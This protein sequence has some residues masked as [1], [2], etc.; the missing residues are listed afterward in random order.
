MK[1]DTEHNYAFRRR[2][3]QVHQP[4]RRNRL[5]TPAAKE[6]AL[7]DD[8]TIVLPLEASDYLFQVAQ[9][10]QDYLA[11]SMNV[12]VKIIRLDQADG[13]AGSDARIIAIG[14]RDDFRERG[15]RLRKPRAF[16]LQV[17]PGRIVI[18]GQDERGAAQGCYRLEDIMNLR[19]APF[20]P[21]Q[22]TV[23][24]PLFA[25]RMVHS[26]WGIDNF[27]D[28][29]LNAIAHAGIDAILV[30]TKDIN[31]TNTGHLDFANLIDR[32]E[33]FGL[34]VYFYSY[35]KSRKHPDD[36]EAV[37]FYENS[38]GKLIRTFPKAKGIVFVGESCEFPSKDERT[39]GRLRLDPAPPGQENDKRPS[40]GWWPCRD[41]PQWL[42]LV[43]GIMR[44]YN[45]DL[46]VVFWTYN[47]GLAPAQDRLALINNLPTDISLEVTFEM[48]ENIVKNG[49][50]TRCVDY[51]A[52]FV[53]PGTYFRTE[54]ETARQRGIPL[55][56]MSNTGGLS[57][58]F[59][60][61]P[62][63]PIPYQWKRRWDALRQ[64]HA[65]WGLNGL[66][67]CHHFGW[68]PSF[69]SELSKEAYWT[70]GDDFDTHLRR[71][72]ER[73]FG[74]DGADDALHAWQLW[75]DAANDYVPTNED[76]YGPFRIGPSYPLLFLDQDITFP[77]V[78]YAHFGARI[79]KPKYRSHAPTDVPAEIALLT[80]MEKKM[81]K[82]VQAL[83]RAARTSPP[84]RREDVARMILLGSFMACAIRTTIHAK[85]WFLC[86]QVLRSDNAARD[87]VLAALDEMTAIAKREIDNARQAI[88]L[89]EQDSRLGWEPSMEYMTD[90]PRL[91]WK[92]AQVTEVINELIPA[93][94]KNL[95][96]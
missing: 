61:I 4:D 82:G 62:Y 26:G 53:G 30:F 75:S 73:D 1:L 80:R 49:I 87:G 94:R 38:Y 89:V 88:P 65:D 56:A 10:L 91:E 63:Q 36:P 66:M 23:R 33:A 74:A 50:N 15:R 59:G 64:A 93:Y 43:K 47:W 25:P 54:A 84:R 7:T 86:S 52:S 39:K 22:D 92:I 34:D 72:A 78:P 79:M 67:E 31:M 83:K 95:T 8:W 58:D 41:Y 24:E 57:W 55:Y 46:D 17:E 5:A 11:V 85:Q 42:N 27:P 19:E 14:A 16:R 68:W 45:P 12:A 37:A 35:M 2:L 60:V 90:K 29:H 20:I 9:D 51:T 76:Q 6:T 3:N 21:Q 48:F 69:I 18:T 28:Q 77:D 40:P 71:L 70:N 13:A 44:Q 32:A 81:R 96:P